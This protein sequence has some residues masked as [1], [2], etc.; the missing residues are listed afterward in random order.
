MSLVWQLAHV[1]D[2]A[3]SCGKACNYHWVLIL[4][5]LGQF[6]L[7][8]ILAKL[9]GDLFIIDQVGSLKVMIM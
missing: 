4:Q 9:N 8:F 5:V 7:G 3:G 6:N 2:D 1:W